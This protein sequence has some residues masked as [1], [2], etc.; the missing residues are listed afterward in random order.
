[1]NVPSI[2]H[3][4][5]SSFFGDLNSD[6]SLKELLNYFYEC[7]KILV[8]NLLIKILKVSELID[9]QSSSVQKQDIEHVKMIQAYLKLNLEDYFDSDIAWFRGYDFCRIQ[10]Q[11]DQH[12]AFIFDDVSITETFH[13]EGEDSFIFSKIHSLFERNNLYYF[14]LA[15][16]VVTQ[17]KFQDLDFDSLISNIKTNRKFGQRDFID[18]QSHEKVGAVAI[19]ISNKEDCL[20]EFSNLRMIITNISHSYVVNPLSLPAKFS[21]QGVVEEKGNENENDD[22]FLEDYMYWC[23]PKGICDMS[24]ELHT[25]ESLSYGR[26]LTMIVSLFKIIDQIHSNNMIWMD[27]KLGNIVKFPINNSLIEWRGFSFMK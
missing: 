23:M 2:H 11:T 8:P 4:N 24:Y 21:I 12:L 18:F 17:D 27:C 10:S 1:M 9:I 19:K 13:E 20:R 16:L 6:V 22:S 3:E 7:L 25:S 15:S 5:L 14:P 26:K